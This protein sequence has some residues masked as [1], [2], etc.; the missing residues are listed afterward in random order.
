MKKERKGEKTPDERAAERS[1]HAADELGIPRAP[2]EPIVSADEI[3]K[4]KNEEEVKPPVQLG[5]DR[6]R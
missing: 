1:E 6:K 2:K 3:S 4:E 5:K